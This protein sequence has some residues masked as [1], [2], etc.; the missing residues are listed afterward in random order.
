MTDQ[1]LDSTPEPVVRPLAVITHEHDEMARVYHI[2][3]GQPVV[4]EAHQLNVQ[5]IG[6]DDQPIFDYVPMVDGDGDPVMDM[7]GEPLTSPQPR[8]VVRDVPEQ[9]LGWVNNRD[10]VFDHEDSRWFNEEGQRRDDEEVAAEQKE[11]IR[12]TLADEQEAAQK[13]AAA[14]VPPRPMPGIGDEL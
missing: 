14:V 10:I 11:I 13:A 1:V 2:I 12:Q 7:T 4:I 8:M 3:I 6:D 9:L 5:A